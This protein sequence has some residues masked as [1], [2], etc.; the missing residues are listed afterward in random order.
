MALPRL[1]NL[2]A[3]ASFRIAAATQRGK[4]REMPTDPYVSFRF[5]A[6]STDTQRV[7]VL[8]SLQS[9]YAIASTQGVENPYLRVQPNGL[10][11]LMIEDD[12]NPN[13]IAASLRVMEPIDLNSIQIGR[14]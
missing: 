12:D 5:R 2:V 1:G 4:P 11:T 13:E 3:S 9:N 6:E 8:H 7:A 14:D 10:H